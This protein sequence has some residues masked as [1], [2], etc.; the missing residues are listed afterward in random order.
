MF[1]SFVRPWHYFWIAPLHV[2][3]VT[4]FLYREVQWVALIFTGLLLTEFTLQIGITY[5]FTKLR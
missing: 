2:V 3:A 1:Q 5:L 4:Y